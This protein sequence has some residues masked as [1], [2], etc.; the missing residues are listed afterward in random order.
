ML[1]YQYGVNFRLDLL[2]ALFKLL[3]MRRTRGNDFSL[4]NSLTPV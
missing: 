2:V 1:L 3:F 4:V